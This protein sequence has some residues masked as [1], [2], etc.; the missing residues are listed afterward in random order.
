MTEEGEG[1][2]TLKATLASSCFS[3]TTQNSHCD[4][5]TASKSHENICAVHLNMQP[6]KT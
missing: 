6:G 3:A 2:K 4:K 5:V 1:V